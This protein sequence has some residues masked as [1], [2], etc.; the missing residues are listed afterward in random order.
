MA[1]RLQRLGL[2]DDATVAYALGWALFESGDTQAAE[3]VLKRIK[4]PSVF[5]DATALR[6]RMAA[7]RLSRAP[8]CP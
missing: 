7:C 8:G 4:D 6:Q 1:P 3:Q 5:N 2:T